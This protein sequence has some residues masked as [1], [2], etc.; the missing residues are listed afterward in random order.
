MVVCCAVD[1]PADYKKYG[2]YQ[3]AAAKKYENKRV[4]TGK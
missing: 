3:E 1:E 2:G 4:K